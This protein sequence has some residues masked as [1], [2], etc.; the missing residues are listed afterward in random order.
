VAPRAGLRRLAQRVGAHGDG[1]PDAGVV[2]RDDC[3]GEGTRGVAGAP[4]IRMMAR[5][6]HGSSMGR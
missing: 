4:E 3:R 6:M 5:V 1:R 2:A